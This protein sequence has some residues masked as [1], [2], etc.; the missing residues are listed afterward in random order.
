MKRNR[1]LILVSNDDGIDAKGLKSLIEIVKPFGDLLIV[2]PNKGQSGMSHSISSNEPLRVCKVEE[3]ENIAAYS[4][5]GTPVDCVKLAINSL[6]DRL[7]DLMVSGIN[8]GSNAAINIIYSG[9]MGAAIEAS[10]HGIPS[11]GFSVDDHSFNADFSIVKTHAVPVIEKVLENGLPEQV[12]LNINYP[13]VSEKDFKGYMICRQTSGVWKEGF[14]KRT[15]P[16]G[17]DY[18]WYTGKFYN[19]EPDDVATDEWALK[20]NYAAIVPVKP[21]FTEYNLINELK[22]WNI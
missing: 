15:D 13:V 3:S 17:R 11:I 19:F 2:A 16:F 12:S 21:D 7:P 8:H 1:K 5:S 18:Y 9:T 20:N 10:L 14:D 6:L 4:V 22:K